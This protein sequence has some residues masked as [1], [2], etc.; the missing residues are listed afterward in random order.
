MRVEPERLD[1]LLGPV[2]TGLPPTATSLYVLLSGPPEGRARIYQQ[3][4]VSTDRLDIARTRMLA[5]VT[6]VPPPHRGDAIRVVQAVSM[7]G[8]HMLAAARIAAHGRP[9]RVPQECLETARAVMV[10][11]DRAATIGLLGPGLGHDVT[12]PAA[13]PAGRDQTAVPMVGPGARLAAV[14]A[15]LRRTAGELDRLT[16]D[17]TASGPTSAQAA[18]SLQVTDLRK[19]H[20]GTWLGSSLDG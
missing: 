4:S 3:M 13:L 9:V 16:T 19:H 17:L 15:V 1:E 8:R 2:L 14:S 12:G 20:P 18:T 6:R 7:L 5:Q 10:L 11:A